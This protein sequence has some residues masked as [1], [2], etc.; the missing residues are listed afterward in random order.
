[1]IMGFSIKWLL[2]ASLGLGAGGFLVFEGNQAPLSRATTSANGLPLERVKIGDRT[3]D[4]EV[5]AT[6][7]AVARG[8]S[9]RATIPDGTGMLFVFPESRILSFWMIDC[10]IEIDVAYVD[11]TGKVVGVYTMKP[12][13]PQAAGE[14]R[15]AYTARLK[16]YPS[17]DDALYAVE[18]P[19]GTFAK[20]GIKSGSMI[21][22]DFAKLRGYLR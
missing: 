18:L 14:T 20:L 19:A 11:R 9:R 16:H 1:M 3:F 4:L 5:A 22:L 12:E 2:V 10:L 6:Q 17:E 21:K 15:D 8:L 7:A 13:P